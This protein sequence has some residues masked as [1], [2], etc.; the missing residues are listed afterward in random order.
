MIKVY[1]IAIIVK[2]YKKFKW[3]TKEELKIKTEYQN[4]HQKTFIQLIV[5]K[6]GS[7]F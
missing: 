3:K 6:N 2:I 4:S 5:H 7:N 1:I